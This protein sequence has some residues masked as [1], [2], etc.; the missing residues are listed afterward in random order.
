MRSRRRRSHDLTD[1]QH[2]TFAAPS[3]HCGTTSRTCKS[4]GRIGG[5]DDFLDMTEHSHLERRWTGRATAR[6]S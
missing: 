5:L 6:R 4:E 2:C 1:G 3:N